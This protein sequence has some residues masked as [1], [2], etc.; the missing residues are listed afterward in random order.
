MKKVILFDLDHTLWD[1]DLSELKALKEFFVFF[2][3]EN[4][5][6]DEYIEKYIEINT[7]M[8]KD[9]EL[10]L[11]SKKELSDTRF[12]K[13]FNY[14]NKKIDGIYAAEIYAN[15][16]GKH[17]D[18]FEGTIELL[19]KLSKDFEIYGATNGITKI[20]KSRL[21]NS[22]IKKYLKK[23]YI[24]DE[25]GYNKPDTRFF[26]YI[27]DDLN[28]SNEDA[29]MIGDNLSADIKGAIDS[30]ISSIWYNAKDKENDLNLKTVEVKGYNKM[31]E[32]IY[33]F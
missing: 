30:N 2:N 10:G 3:I 20:Q 21:E 14:F 23:V 31:L 11:I 7:K 16:L 29:L 22:K 5:K 13:L 27:L 18:V 6:I 4:D 26:K 25:I 9:F 8:W 28:I 19:E 24:S 15:I 12:E 17:G 33:K 1:F 32:E